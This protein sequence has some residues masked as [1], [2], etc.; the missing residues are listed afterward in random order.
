MNRYFKKKTTNWGENQKVLKYQYNECCQSYCIIDCISQYHVCNAV[1]KLV[2][3][4]RIP[5]TLSP[6]SQK[7]WQSDLRHL[8]R[9]FCSGHTVSSPD[10]GGTVSLCQL[11]LF[12]LS[13][14]LWHQRRDSQ[15]TQSNNKCTKKRPSRSTSKIP[16][17]EHHC[18]A[19]FLT[20]SEDDCSGP[21]WGRLKLF[22]NPVLGWRG[23]KGMKTFLKKPSRE[24]RTCSPCTEGMPLGISSYFM[25]FYTP[26]YYLSEKQEREGLE[27]APKVSWITYELYKPQGKRHAICCLL[28][29]VLLWQHLFS[30]IAGSCP[31][32][33][34]VLISLVC[35]VCWYFGRQNIKCVGVPEEKIHI[36]TAGNMH[37][38]FWFMGSNC[39]W[40]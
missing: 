12:F 24:H 18:S 16:A 39:L 36:S 40:F 15:D 9:A 5:S 31:V 38:G 13:L 8:H 35:L 32:T 17:L 11:P 10:T 37:R 20:R 22:M 28:T 29:L 30:V 25:Q 3:F 19:L 1:L 33:L 21:S 6:A 7:A 2:L 23:N 14:Q 27:C 34:I 4:T 26:P